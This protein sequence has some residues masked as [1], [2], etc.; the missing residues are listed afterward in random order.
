MINKVMQKLC[1]L[2]S[3]HGRLHQGFEYLVYGIALILIVLL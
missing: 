1:Y 2:C 3:K